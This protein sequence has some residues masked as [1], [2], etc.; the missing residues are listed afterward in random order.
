MSRDIEELEVVFWLSVH[1]WCS[2]LSDRSLLVDTLSYFS[3]QPVPHDRFNKDP[4]MCYPVCGMVHI[5]QPLLLIKKKLNSTDSIEFHK[6]ML[7]NKSV[8]G[9]V[10]ASAPRLV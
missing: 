9:I 3:F 5:K 1:S 6:P 8:L 2:G 10:Q 4:H 7:S